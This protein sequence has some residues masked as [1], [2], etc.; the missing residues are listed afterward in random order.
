MIVELQDGCVR[1]VVSFECQ[2][3]APHFWRLVP[4]EDCMGLK[5]QH[6]DRRC[7]VEC[8]LQRFPLISGYSVAGR[9]GPG[10]EYTCSYL[11]S[12]LPGVINRRQCWSTALTI[13]HVVRGISFGP[14]LDQRLHSCPCLQANVIVS[15]SQSFLALI[16]AE[17]EAVDKVANR[18]S[19]APIVGETLR[20]NFASVFSKENV[21]CQIGGDMYSSPTGNGPRCEDASASAGRLLD[22]EKSNIW[23]L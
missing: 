8:L 6:I 11:L 3:R 7:S 20:T 15:R 10:G 16:R 9:T 22:L 4:C 5:C 14:G 13:H 2:N 1:T 18:E 17:R 19:L 12:Q 23:V 21:S